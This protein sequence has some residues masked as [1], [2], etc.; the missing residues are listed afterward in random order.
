MV[1]NQGEVH[2]VGGCPSCALVVNPR[3]T[4]ILLHI[5]TNSLG[6][7]YLLLELK[8]FSTGFLLCLFL[9]YMSRTRGC[10]DWMGGEDVHCP[11]KRGANWSLKY[12]ELT[13]DAGNANSGDSAK[14]APPQVINMHLAGPSRN[15]SSRKRGVWGLQRSL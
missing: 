8:I 12:R 3:V 5:P 14:L 13:H 15:C 9:R 11:V 7:Q 6:I 2:S 10:R 1:S 4:Y